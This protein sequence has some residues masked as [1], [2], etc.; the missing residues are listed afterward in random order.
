MAAD[1]GD[2]AEDPRISCD[3]LRFRLGEPVHITDAIHVELFSTQNLFARKIN[4]N[5]APRILGRCTAMCRREIDDFRNR[6]AA[7]RTWPV[8]PPAEE[9]RAVPPAPFTLE[10]GKTYLFGE[11]GGGKCRARSRVGRA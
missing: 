11:G 2:V 1:H 8:P 5:H 3:N 7:P 9:R 10:P 6:L 4:L